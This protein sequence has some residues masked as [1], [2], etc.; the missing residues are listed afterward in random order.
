MS[1]ETP[2]EVIGLDKW[3]LSSRELCEMSG[4][5]RMGPSPS[6]RLQTA[7]SRQRP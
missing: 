7:S 3:K 6:L 4:G 5:W 2:V 1:D